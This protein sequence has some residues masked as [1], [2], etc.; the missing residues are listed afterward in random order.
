MT[1]IQSENLA[2]EWAD[3]P[4]APELWDA[5]QQMQSNASMGI[6]SLEKLAG[7]GSALAMMRLGYVHLS[8]QYGVAENADMGEA[9]LRR[10][11]ESGSIEGAFRLANLL[12]AHGRVDEAM[13][14]FCE[15]SN[16]GYSPATFILGLEL[17]RG[18]YIPR[19]VPRAMNYLDS[20]MQQGHLRA[21]HWLSHILIREERGV[22]PLLRG[23]FIRLSMMVPFVRLTVYRPK[24]D[25]LRIWA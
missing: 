19:D 6:E 12:L 25:R 13:A 2:R 4:L 16:R 20:A 5:I 8:G 24:S 14:F 7:A 18:H 9:W 23:L 10:S 17:H 15:L 11:A 22:R 1:T 21:A 3:D